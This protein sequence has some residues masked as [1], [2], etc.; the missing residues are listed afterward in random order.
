MLV[1]LFNQ[2][3]G[4]VIDAPVKLAAD[5]P[6]IPEAVAVLLTVG[7]REKP[8]VAAIVPFK[9]PLSAANVCLKEPSA[10]LLATC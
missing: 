4:D 8:S 10:N 7:A 5:P 3:E 1:A 6:V 9:A 2:V